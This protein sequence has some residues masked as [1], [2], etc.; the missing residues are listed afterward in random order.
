V[1]KDE[2]LYYP[3]KGPHPNEPA[4]RAEVTVEEALG[5]PE[6]K[7]PFRGRPMKR[8]VKPGSVSLGI[9]VR[10]GSAADLVLTNE[11]SLNPLPIKELAK[12]HGLKPETLHVTRARLRRGGAI[13]TKEEAVKLPERKRRMAEAGIKL[14]LPKKR[15]DGPEDL[16]KYF[17]RIEDEKVLTEQ[18]VTQRMS[19]LARV[20]SE[21]TRKYALTKLKEWH[22]E[23]AVNIGPAPP[24]DDTGAGARYERLFFARQD[25][26]VIAAAL[27]RA[28]LAAAAEPPLATLFTAANQPPMNPYSEEALDANAEAEAP[29]PTSE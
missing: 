1:E 28:K 15:V 16:E 19:R 22:R 13:P 21:E 18:E 6:R 27:K 11:K 17:E 10:R 5:L 9:K 4:E 12:L 26:T 20:G 8:R 24:L 25:W 14:P 3:E 29:A 2:I 23:K 7:K